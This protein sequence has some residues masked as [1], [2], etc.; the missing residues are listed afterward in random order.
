MVNATLSLPVTSGTSAVY[1]DSFVHRLSKILCSSLI[2][3]LLIRGYFQKKGNI[4]NM[5]STYNIS[6]AVLST[7]TRNQILSSNNSQHDKNIRNSTINLSMR[8]LK[9]T[10]EFVNTIANKI[11]NDLPNFLPDFES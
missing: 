2:Y 8:N 7:S 1:V 6:P 9:L 11:Y 10:P 5:F 4:K 3:L